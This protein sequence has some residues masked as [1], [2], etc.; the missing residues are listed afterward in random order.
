MMEKGGS[1]PSYS[2]FFEQSSE[3]MSY[4]IQCAGKG[5][6]QMQKRRSSINAKA[7]GA[8]RARVELNCRGNLL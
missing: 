8:K 4:A 1:F 3:A 6:M 2:L 7:S 5:E